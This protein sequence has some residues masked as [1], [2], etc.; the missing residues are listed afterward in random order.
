[1]EKEVFNTK[2]KFWIEIQSNLIFIG[3]VELLIYNVGLL[4]K[5]AIQRK[6]DFFYSLSG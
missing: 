4:I 2:N 5:Y 3:L 6:Y 1:M